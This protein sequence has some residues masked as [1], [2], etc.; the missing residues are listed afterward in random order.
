MGKVGVLRLLRGS[1]ILQSAVLRI[2][3]LRLREA[4]ARPGLEGRTASASVG[5]QVALQNRFNTIPFWFPPPSGGRSP[6]ATSAAGGGLPQVE[7]SI[8]DPQLYLPPI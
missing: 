3:L 8:M 6:L 2:R 4:V 7:V 1:V 5:T